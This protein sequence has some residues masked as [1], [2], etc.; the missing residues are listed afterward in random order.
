VLD[1]TQFGPL[2]WQAFGPP[3]TPPRSE[4]CLKIN[5]WTGAV[6]E[7]VKRPVML[8]IHGDGFEFESSL[9]PGYD[10]AHM[11]TKGVVMPTSITVWDHSGI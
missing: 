10:G 7:K 3:G 2:C 11:A 8:W 4:D 5:V 1:A 6:E 9:D